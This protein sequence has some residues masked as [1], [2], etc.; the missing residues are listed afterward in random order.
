MPGDDD[1]QQQEDELLALASI[2]GDGF[3]ADHEAAEG[4]AFVLLLPDADAAVRLAFRAHL[5]SAYPSRD[6]PVLDLEL[7]GVPGV[8]A[9]EQAL[10]ELAEEL[11]AAFVPGEVCLYGWI[12]R[13]REWL[14]T[15][16]GALCPEPKDPAQREDKPVADPLPFVLE[17][18][19]R[20]AANEDR[21]QSAAAS[22]DPGILRALN[23]IVHGEPYM[24]KKSTF[25]AHVATVKS[26][27][28]VDE[29]MACLLENNKVRAASHNMLAYRIRLHG[30][31]SSGSEAF[32][33]DYDDD[34]ETAAGSRML[35]LLQLAAVEDVVVVVS[36]W[37][38]GVLL[39]PS[40]FA[41][42]NNVAR[43]LLEQEG[44]IRNAS[45]ADGGKKKGK[46]H[47]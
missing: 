18:K 41:I 38:G 19:V 17:E 4:R 8:S 46:K 29:V 21:A 12:E 44:Y 43:Q 27:T 30:D 42:I 2:Y 32:L 34:G 35:H 5:P 9:Q 15:L 24:E 7:N 6:P 36:R 28:E 33:Q 31:G 47:K 1:D 39:G 10:D 22:I 25:Q 45:G 40:R 11:H 26:Q 14:D 37:F 20:P 23:S 13:A 3:R 16:A